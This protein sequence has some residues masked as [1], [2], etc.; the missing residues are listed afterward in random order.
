MALKAQQPTHSPP[1]H[2]TATASQPGTTSPSHVLKVNKTEQQE[3]SSQP[4]QATATATQP[5]TTS[6]NH[7]QNIDKT[8]Q[9]SAGAVQS[10]DSKPHTSTAPA[11]S[12][13]QLSQP[14]CAS[15]HTRPVTVNGREHQQSAEADPGQK[16]NTGKEDNSEA[17]LQRLEQ[18]FV[19][20]VYNAI[21]PHF[22]ATRFAIWPKVHTAFLTAA[23]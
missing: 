16:A 20:D 13:G 21:A 4:D 18:E 7:E 19:H 11:Q 6:P 17:E 2:A 8:Q 9:A 15:G 23:A 3:S 1:L 5:G 22:S 12:G 10:V 14:P